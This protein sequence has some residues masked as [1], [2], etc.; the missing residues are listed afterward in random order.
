MTV[1]VVEPKPSTAP[2]PPLPAYSVTVNVSLPTG[3]GTIV[4][5]VCPEVQLRIVGEPSVVD[6][7]E[8]AIDAELVP[9]ET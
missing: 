4:E 2:C 8:T 3:A 7:V 6:P 1:C 5:H 9:A